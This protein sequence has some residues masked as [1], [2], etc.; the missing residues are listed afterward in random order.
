MARLGDK[1]NN[2]ET[3]SGRKMLGDKDLDYL[4]HVSRQS[5]E[6]HGDFSVLY[7]ALDWERSKRN[8][9]GELLM[10]K[11]KVVK[12]V[13]LKVKYIIKEGEETLQNNIPNQ[14][15]ELNVS[16]FVQQLRELDIDPKLDDYF[17]LGQRLYRIWRSRARRCGWMATTGT[18]V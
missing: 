10:K 7:F 11:F 16:V 1:T 9:Y 4:E 14:L 8:F 13:P 12:G 2:K 6:E 15:L 17:A 5:V 18:S 3:K